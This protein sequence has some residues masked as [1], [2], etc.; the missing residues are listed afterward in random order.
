MEFR[1]RSSI[2]APACMHSSTRKKV[3]NFN[4]KIILKRWVEAASEISI[5]EQIFL[6]LTV[7]GM[8]IREW[9]RTTFPIKALSFLPP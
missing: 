8:A 5:A 1:W 2:K 4:L 3:C 7:V 6:P 9:L